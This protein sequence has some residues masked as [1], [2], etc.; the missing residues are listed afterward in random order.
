L[1]PGEED[2]GI[3]PVEA[4]ACGAPVIALGLGGAAETVDNTVGKLYCDPHPSSLEAGIEV[5][6]AEGCR[7]DPVPGRE[8]A[9]SF[10][11]PLFRDRVFKLLAEVL[12][13]ASRTGGTARP[14]ISVS[15]R[16]SRSTTKS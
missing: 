8:R 4:L 6:E 16:G 12:G 15:P 1:F 2:F 14:H 9:E 13:S 5:W 3:V 10:S 11:L 7:H